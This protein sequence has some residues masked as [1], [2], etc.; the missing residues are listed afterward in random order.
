MTA[1]S[2]KQPVTARD[3]IIRF[4]GIVK[5]FGGAQRWQERR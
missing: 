1:I 3:D 2:L 5:R 4:E